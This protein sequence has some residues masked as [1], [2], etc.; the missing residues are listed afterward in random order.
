MG[1]STPLPQVEITNEITLRETSDDWSPST[2]IGAVASSIAREG[3]CAVVFQACGLGFFTFS[4]FLMWRDLDS[5]TRPD[6]LPDPCPVVYPT[7]WSLE[8]R[9][10]DNAPETVPAIAAGPPPR[11]HGIPTSFFK[12]AMSHFRSAISHTA[13]ATR[14]PPPGSTTTGSSGLPCTVIVTMGF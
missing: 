14:Q 12:A 6:P 3:R 11:D 13:G 10:R 7:G 1:Q 9:F 4:K 5:R 2:Y 8:P